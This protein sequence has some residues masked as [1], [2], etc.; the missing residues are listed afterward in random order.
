MLLFSRFIP[1]NIVF[2]S[3]ISEFDCLDFVVQFLAVGI[4]DTCFAFSFPCCR[5]VAVI[6]VVN[7]LALSLKSTH[8]F[9]RFVCFC[10]QLQKEVK[11][12]KKQQ[13]QIDKKRN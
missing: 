6:V 5:C 13:N 2:F 7:L 4:V 3:R 8:A 1:F 11:T 9:S 10:L 12:P